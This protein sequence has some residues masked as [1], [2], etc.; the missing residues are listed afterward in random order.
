MNFNTIV[1]IE[2][3]A[4]AICVMLCQ[5]KYQHE[6]FNI[7]NSIADVMLFQVI[8]IHYF[9]V[10]SRNIMTRILYSWMTLAT[11]LYMIMVICYYICGHHDILDHYNELWII[12][13]LVFN[14]GLFIFHLDIM[15][16]KLFYQD[17]YGGSSIILIGIFNLRETF[18]HHL[19]GDAQPMIILYSS[20]F[21]PIMLI[22]LVGVGLV[23]YL[24]IRII[25][26]IL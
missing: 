4:I 19:N 14:S 20:L 7:Y 15:E 21:Y 6:L 13:S 25:R 26:R 1:V 9:F 12:C 8:F 22:S 5:I 11:G 24:M 18:Y 10:S 17:I 3:M 16:N 23:V 2:V